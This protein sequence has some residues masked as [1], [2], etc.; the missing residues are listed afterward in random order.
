MPQKRKTKKQT[1]KSTFPF[2]HPTRHGRLHW[3]KGLLIIVL[4]SFGLVLA[5]AITAQAA[6]NRI[7]WNWM[8]EHSTVKITLLI[9]SAMRGLDE[10][11]SMPEKT[12]DG[13]LLIKEARLKLPAETSEVRKLLYF[14]S[15]SNS[16][17]Q[18]PDEPEILQITTGQISTLSRERLLTG[19]TVDHVFTMVPEAQACNRGMTIEFQPNNDFGLKLSGSKRL[20]DGRTLYL[21]REPNCK[22]YDDLLNSL[23]TH[24]LRAESY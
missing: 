3:K 1:K 12:D 9:Q 16:T 18:V 15:P 24:L 2:S 7:V 13:A 11:K 19:Q 17:Y 20:Q 5:A 4:G 22:H 10:L 6:Y 14:Y 23:E 8:Q 21:Y